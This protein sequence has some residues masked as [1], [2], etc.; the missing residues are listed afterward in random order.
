MFVYPNNSI[1]RGQMK[2]KDESN[3]KFI[4]NGEGL[5]MSHRN[6]AN[7]GRMSYDVNG[8]NSQDDENIQEFRHGYGI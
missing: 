4:S 3:R 2:K 6:S 5:N 1:Y 8:P 7:A